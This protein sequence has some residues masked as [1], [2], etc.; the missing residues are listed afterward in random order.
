MLEDKT[1]TQTIF[2]CRFPENF[3]F[4]NLLV[5]F[6]FHNSFPS[7]NALKQPHSPFLSGPLVTVFVEISIPDLTKS[8]TSVLAVVLGS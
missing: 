4:L 2:C 6:R 1:S 7:S 8:L 5:G 3:D